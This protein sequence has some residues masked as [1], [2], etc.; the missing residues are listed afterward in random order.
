MIK[1]EGRRK[2]QEGRSFS[3]IRDKE[4]GKSFSYLWREGRKKEKILVI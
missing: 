2:R 4:E 1:E 3:Y